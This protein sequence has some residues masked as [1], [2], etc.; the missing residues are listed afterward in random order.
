MGELVDILKNYMVEHN[1]TQPQLD[2]ALGVSHETIRGW[3][4]T[5]KKHAEPSKENIIK[6]EKFLESVRRLPKKQGLLQPEIGLTVGNDT[7]EKA[8]KIPLIQKEIDW[9]SLLSETTRVTVRIV[10]SGD[11]S[12]TYLERDLVDTPQYQRLRK[13]KQLGSAYL[14]FPTALHTRFDHSL[15]T[16]HI[17]GE[18]IWNIE[19][20]PLSSPDQRGISTKDKILTRLAALLHDITHIPFGHTL[21]DDGGIFI[22]HDQDNI[23][24]E[25][26]LG[27][28]TDIFN[29]LVAKI[30]RQGYSGLLNIL[31]SSHEPSPISP[32]T[33]YI[34][35][36]I[37][38]TVCADLLDY[39]LRD[40]YFCGIEAAFGKRF[41][42][43]LFIDR[44]NGARRLIVRTAKEKRGIQYPRR[45][46]ISE[47]VQLLS[48]RYDL[49]EK[50]YYHHT[51]IAT[52]AMLVRAVW[53][54]V[55]A[56]WEE[57]GK[58][59]ECP[60]EFLAMGDEQ[61]LN[62]LKST[63]DI[64]RKLIEGIYNHKLHKRIWLL[65]R[66]TALA[67]RHNLSTFENEFGN[68]AANRVYWEN[69]L[70]RLIGASN[71][72]VLI[73]CPSLKMQK[74]YAEMLITWDGTVRQLNTITEEEDWATN[75][76]LHAI[77]KLH[78]AL[79][80]INVVATKE[81]ADN[82]PKR[83]LLVSMCKALI[84]PPGTDRDHSLHQAIRN[85]IHII[86]S[87]AGGSARAVD[88][89]TE[90]ALT[91]AR[92]TTDT[93][94]STI[95]DAWIGQRLNTFNNR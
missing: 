73:F 75:M 48:T 51:K 43:Y 78:D 50:V 55:S 82:E 8:Q 45:D 91:V 66:Q 62:M 74:K 42:R 69:Y 92:S 93:V 87:K 44:V 22:R 56:E 60:T 31:K 12:L 34:S 23:R 64:A 28:G 5:G 38:N 49:A 88:E 54:K 27:E 76:S 71:G 40:P 21:E 58:P 9:E 19:R 29:K 95:T 14:I 4:S 61:F 35:D 3:F 20:N 47:L 67:A 63:N 16:L 52:D 10:P 37:G 7:T 59:I 2:Q 6:I 17:A 33:A 68:N 26:L 70:S 15:G 83:Q 81:I 84:A 90:E 1:L 41:M 11:V 80:G 89:V 65:D 72:D 86:A 36:I 18:F 79:W 24:Y 94:G 53:E 30:D 13:I 57:A 25:V 39:L 85:R 46:I 32:D 77:L